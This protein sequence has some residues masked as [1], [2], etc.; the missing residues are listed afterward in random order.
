MDLA[1]SMELAR[2]ASEDAHRRQQGRAA[3][4]PTTLGLSTSAASA[5]STPGGSG[6]GGGFD[7]S[8]PDLAESGNRKQDP[9]SLRAR[10]HT[11]CHRELNSAAGQMKMAIKTG[12]EL[13]GDPRIDATM[14]K[15]FEE[16]LSSRLLLTM[17]VLGVAWQN[18][19]FEEKY[20]AVEN[21]QTRTEMNDAALKD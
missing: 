9:L 4:S 10:K 1:G 8:R 6:C 21:I 2:K 16:N 15:H 5:P 13:K 14:D 7:R 12:L 20:A 19:D 17:E 18:G 11:Q 3:G